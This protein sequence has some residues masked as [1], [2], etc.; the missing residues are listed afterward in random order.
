MTK[1][2]NNIYNVQVVRNAWIAVEAENES[3]AMSIAQNVE[4]ENYIDD[5]EFEESEIDV[6]ACETYSRG[7]DDMF[8]SDDDYILT[9]DGAMT[10]EEYRN[11][12]ENEL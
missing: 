11:E 2:T 9:K 12:L 3:E 10:A 4:L 6:F 1:R 7:I 5:D 8:L